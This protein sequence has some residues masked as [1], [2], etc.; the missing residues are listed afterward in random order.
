MKT[1]ELW[2]DKVLMVV[3]FCKNVSLRSSLLKRNFKTHR[4]RI[5][6]TVEFLF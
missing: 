5:D 6:R 1:F 2:I 3:V 4:G